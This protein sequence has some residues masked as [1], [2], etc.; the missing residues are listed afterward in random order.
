MSLDDLEKK[1]T[2]FADDMERRFNEFTQKLENEF[3]GKK[4]ETEKYRDALETELNFWRFH[5][6]NL[7]C[8]AGVVGDL[9]SAPIPNSP[10]P[11][12]AI[13]ADKAYLN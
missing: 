8:Q 11:E 13:E 9:A 4:T 12:M 7:L 5:A 6:N 3:S 2:E 1:F 10:R